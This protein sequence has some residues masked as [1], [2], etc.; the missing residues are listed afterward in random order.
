MKTKLV[1]LMKFFY[2]GLEVANNSSHDMLSDSSN[3][4]EQEN[5]RNGKIETPQQYLMLLRKS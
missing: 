4:E 3:T 2:E 5:G 1:L